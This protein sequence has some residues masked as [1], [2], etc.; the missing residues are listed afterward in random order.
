VSRRTLPLDDRLQAFVLEH[1]VREHPAQVGLREATARLPEADM[2]SSPEQMQLLGLL[3]RLIG[4]RRVLE[5][6][7]FTGYGALSMALHLPEDGRVVTL[8]AERDWPEIG[9]PFWRDAG[10]AERIELRL[11]PA[12]D[13][14]RAL[15]EQ[16]EVFDLA[17]IDADKRGYDHYYEASLALVRP[18][19][20]VALDNML[21]GGRIADPA[22]TAPQV[23]VLRALAAKIRDDERVDMAL[24]PVGDGVALVRRR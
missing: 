8:D 9:R 22:E 2:Q 14:L 20:L 16:G 10:V 18:G 11:G 24:L 1:G 12:K 5:I 19:G 6:G 4:A 15:Q 3:L 7:C 21:W 17:Y 13:S 23:R